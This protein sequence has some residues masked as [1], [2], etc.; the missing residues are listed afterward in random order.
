[1]KGRTYFVL[2]AGVAAVAVSLGGS[3]PDPSSRS[4]YILG[5]YHMEKYEVAKKMPE[6][7]RNSSVAEVT[8]RRGGQYS[9]YVKNEA[10]FR[11]MRSKAVG[12]ISKDGYHRH[13]AKQSSMAIQKK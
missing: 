13:T 8:A 2:L 3:K 10:R 5:K 4:S 9:T 7:I 12:S 1:M 11:M 6:S